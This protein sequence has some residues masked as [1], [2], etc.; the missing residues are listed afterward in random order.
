[1]ML[2]ELK[3]YLIEKQEATLEE[4]SQ[5]FHEDPDIIADML[6][7]WINKGN[8]VKTMPTDACGGCNL[9]CGMSHLAIYSW[10][11]KSEGESHA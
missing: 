7:H 11:N 5:H 2:L 4:L 6:E 9:T 1:M 10:K 3:K 8:V